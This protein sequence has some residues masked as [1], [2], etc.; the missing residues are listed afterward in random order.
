MSQK[1]HCG[2]EVSDHQNA[3]EKCNAENCKCQIV[4]TEP[5][6]RRPVESSNLKSVGYSLMH[7]TLTIEFKNKLNVST[8]VYFYNNVSSETFNEFFKTFDN[9]E[10]SAGSYAAKNFRKLP[11]FGRVMLKD[12]EENEQKTEPTTN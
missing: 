12:K 8:G 3:T 7:R 6:D 5:I 4:I 2:H 10:L 9:P 11:H 1:C